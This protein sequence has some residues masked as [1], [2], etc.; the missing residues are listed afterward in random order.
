MC[1]VVGLIAAC[2]NLVPAGLQVFAD[3]S[4]PDRV[5]ELRQSSPGRFRV[6]EALVMMSTQAVN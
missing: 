4:R 5:G 2:G 1:L 3:M 6:E